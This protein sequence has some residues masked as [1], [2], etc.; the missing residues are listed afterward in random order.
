VDEQQVEKANQLSSE[1]PPSVVN[2]LKPGISSD[3]P[4]TDERF[5]FLCVLAQQEMQS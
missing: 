5:S 1:K 2:T 4:I 3:F